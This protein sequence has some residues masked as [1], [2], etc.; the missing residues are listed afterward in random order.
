MSVPELLISTEI[1]YEDEAVNWDKNMRHGRA[2]LQQIYKEWSYEVANRFELE[3]KDVRGVCLHIKNRLRVRGCSEGT[4][5][6]VAECLDPGFKDD[7]RVK[8]FEDGNPSS[9]S[10]VYED[11]DAKAIGI[12]YRSD[13]E[14]MSQ[15]ELEEIIPRALSLKTASIK[16]TREEVATLKKIA[17]EHNI[18]I[19]E[20]EKISAPIPPEY[21]HGQSEFWYSIG[22]MKEEILK[23]YNQFDDLQQRVYYFKPDKELAHSCATKMD[24]FRKT[25]FYKMRFM[26]MLMLKNLQSILTP[27]T[28]L[29]WANT[30][31]GWFQ[32]GVDVETKYGNKGCGTKHAVPTGEYVLKVYKDGHVELVG[33]DRE[34]T[35]EQ[36][37]DKTRVQL[38]KM[39]LIQA[40]A[41]KCEQAVS[42]WMTKTELVEEVMSN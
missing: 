32:M 30:R 26:C 37:G 13:V 8:H 35:K 34:F 39:A 28:D 21:F 9:T 18:R 33:L 6:Y 14:T 29:K 42:D 20:V 27:A 12:H 11:L 25:G 4:V 36:T 5:D 38:L 17:F 24:E 23:I 3:K 15:A 19:P 41:N 7:T 31:V 2:R 16:Q 10:T 1:N 40:Q 22:G